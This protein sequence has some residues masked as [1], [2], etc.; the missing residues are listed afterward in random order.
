M[1]SI[2]NTVSGGTRNGTPVAPRRRVAAWLAA[3]ALFSTA[4]HAQ[5]GLATLSSPELSGPVTVFYPSL[6]ADQPVQREQRGQTAL[7]AAENGAP[8]PGNGRLIVISHGSGGGPWTFTDLARRWVQAGFVV[9]LPEHQGDNWHDVKDAGPASWKRRPLEISHAIDA[10]L[11]DARWAGRLDANKVGMYGMS[12]GGHTAL[13][14]AGGRWSPARLAAHCEAHIGEDFNTCVGLAAEL[15]GGPFDGLKK[16]I[17]RFVLRH[18]LTDATEQQHTDPRIAAIAAEVPL[19]AD[20]DFA[21]LAQ[22]VVPL[23]LVRAGSD[24][25][26]VP[27]FHIDRV[28][29]ACAACELLADLPEAGHGAFLSPPVPN[30]PPLLRKLLSYDEP[31]APAQV[32]QAHERLVDYFKRML[33]DR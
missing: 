12:A 16:A 20:F 14:L 3:L 28:R 9:A 21:T 1:K 5:L 32:Q 23:G 7:M 29:A 17:A 25:W 2:V 4:A 30:P 19:A 31:I 18:L 22:P 26:L 10:V 11:A 15:N 13:V 33:L 6:D 27:R 24:R 8:A